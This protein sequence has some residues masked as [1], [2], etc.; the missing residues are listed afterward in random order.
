MSDCASCKFAFANMGGPSE[1]EKGQHC[2]M[3]QDKVNNCAQYTKVGERY[4]ANKPILSPTAVFVLALAKGLNDH[5]TQG[6]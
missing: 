3:F 4:M 1:E 2:Y 6:Q 5:D